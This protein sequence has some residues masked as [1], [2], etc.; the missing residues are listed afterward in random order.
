MISFDPSNPGITPDDIRS[1]IIRE[2]TNVA[3]WA[4][5][6]ASLTPATEAA[7]LVA[8]TEMSKHEALLRTWE[9]AS[10]RRVPRSGFFRRLLGRTF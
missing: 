1:G 6:I 3:E 2:R 10:K 4:R 8:M 7:R 5:R 9:V